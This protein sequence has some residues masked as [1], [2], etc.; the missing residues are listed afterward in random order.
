MRGSRFSKCKINLLF[1]YRASMRCLRPD[2]CVIIL[3]KNDGGDD[4][5]GAGLNDCGLLFRR[6]IVILDT[7]LGAESR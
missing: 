5:E 4:G 1:F 2:V 7:F 3:S 6:R